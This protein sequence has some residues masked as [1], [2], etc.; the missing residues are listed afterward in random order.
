M[1][2]ALGLMSGTSMDGID[3]ALI[4]TDGQ[5]QVVRGPAMHFPYTP[6]QRGMIKQAIQDARLCAQARDRPGRLADVERELT[7]LHGAAVSAFLRKQEIDRDDI[8]LVSLHGQTVAH[9]PDEKLTVQLGDGRF[10]A[11][12]VR[13]PVVHN[14]RQNDMAHGGHGAPLAPAYHAALV[15]DIPD[16]PI[17]IVNIGGVSNVTWID[18]TGTLLSFDSG[19]GNAMLDDWMTLK[20]GQAMDTGGAMASKGRVCDV[21]LHALLD[22]PF[23]K[24]K[25]PKSLDRNAFDAAPVLELSLEDGAA[26]LVAFAVQSI[27]QAAAWFPEPPQRWVITGGGRYNA[28]MMA[29]LSDD[30]AAPVAAAETHGLDGDSVEAEAWAYLG[31]R[32]ALGLPITFPGTTGVAQPLTGGEFVAWPPVP[33]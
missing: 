28:Y 24:M 31:V 13:R 4:R 14:L 3:V 8:D 22:N 7:E 19:P 15:N 27:T 6:E 1:K 10:F 32:A 25:P 23:F 33:D 9:R 5:M 12:L 11:E 29:R 2:T 20:A 16:R 30:L 21:A 18:R 17:V 26:T